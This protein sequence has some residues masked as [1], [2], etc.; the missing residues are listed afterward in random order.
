MYVYILLAL[1]KAT[2]II[3]EHVTTYYQTLKTWMG[4]NGIRYH[5]RCYTRYHKFSLSLTWIDHD[6]TYYHKFSVLPHTLSYI[7]SE[8][9]MIWGYLQRVTTRYRQIHT[10]NIY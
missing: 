9:N 2:P 5:T 6:A 10:K 8:R 4:H 7:F 1:T 3:F